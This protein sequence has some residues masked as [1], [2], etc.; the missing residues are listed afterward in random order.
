M[1]NE[2][3]WTPRPWSQPVDH[4]RARACVN[5]CTGL[6][7]PAAAIQAAREAINAMLD[8]CTNQMGEYSPTQDDYSGENYPS[9]PAWD[10]LRSALSIL[11]PKGTP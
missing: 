11:T 10:A 9:R 7:D 3:Q 6:P 2:P 1:S 5:A 8:E 4:D